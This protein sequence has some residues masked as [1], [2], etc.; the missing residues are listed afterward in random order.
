MSP[1]PRD[2]DSIDAEEAPNKPD[3]SPENDT[4]QKQ[5]SS[6]KRRTK[7]GCLIFSM[8]EE[9]YKM[10][11]REAVYRQQS[12]EP[13]NP[14]FDQDES[15]GSNQFR[16]FVSGSFPNPSFLSET[17]NTAPYQTF[18]PSGSSS[19][20]HLPF[21][22]S[23]HA[24]TPTFA[25]GQ[26]PLG[27]TSQSEWQ[28]VQNSVDQP[29]LNMLSSPGLVGPSRVIDHNYYAARTEPNYDQYGQHTNSWGPLG[30]WSISPQM[31]YPTPPFPGEMMFQDH[32]QSASD[33]PQDPSQFARNPF[34]HG[35]LQEEPH[36]GR[37]YHGDSSRQFTPSSGGASFPNS[38][39]PISA[40]SGYY[41]DPDD[42]FDVDSEEENLSYQA[43]AENLT[44]ALD[45]SEQH[46]RRMF[47]LNASRRASQ[48]L[49]NFRPSTTISPLREERNQHLFRHFVE[50]TSQCISVFERHHFSSIAGPARTLWNFTLPSMAMSHPALAHGILALGALH[51]SKLQKAS[52]ATAVKHFT[53]AVRR[54]GRLLGLPMRRLEIATLATVLVLGFYEVMSGDHSRWNLHL[55][56]ATSLVLEHD[57]AGMTRNAR[58]MRNGAKARVNQWMARFA[59]T[60]ENYAR[61]AGIPLALL[62]DID[63]D[64]DS[65][66]IS[67]LTGLSVNYDHQVQPQFPTQSLAASLTDKD[68]EDFKAKMDLRWWYCKQDVFQSCI[69]GDRLMLPFEDWKYCPP[70]GQLG[71]SANPYATLDHLCLIMARIADYSGK[72]RVRKQRALAAAG[73]EWRPPTWLFGPQGP[74]SGKSEGSKSPGLGTSSAS[75]HPGKS[76]GSNMSAGT[77]ASKA[78]TAPSANEGRARQSKPAPKG[79]SPPDRLPTIGMIPPPEAPIQMHSAFKTMD[80]N[81][82]DPAFTGTTRD[83]KPTQPRNLEDETSRAFKEHE[84]ITSAFDLFARSLGPDFDPLPYTDTPIATPFGPALVYRNPGIACIW[85]FYHVGRILLCRSHPEMPPAAMVAA[86][87]TA[88]LTRDHAQ[89]IGKICAGLYATQQYNQSGALDPTFAGACMEST[90]YL[91]FAGVQY[92]DPGQRG[93]T[94]SKLRDISQRCGWHT[95]AAVAA[96]C[97]TT[98]ERMGQAGRAPPYERKLDP[99]NHDDRQTGLGPR[100]PDASPMA[101]D[102]SNALKDHESAFVVHDRSLIDRSNSTRVHWALGLLS[103]EEDIKNM[104]LNE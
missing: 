34:R 48:T 92:T 104:K 16:T 61:V 96:A 28:S 76:G 19:Y 63:W 4:A 22:A 65:A 41:D 100:G 62:D 87:V 53:Y 56:G 85:A 86:S 103:V 64:V 80:A 37:Q 25:E 15:M 18:D 39:A 40:G 102:S 21:S 5:Q 71:R 30:P 89:A 7:T 9:T 29:A 66:L 27:P 47:R 52:D 81:L 57:Y 31:P 75:P 32:S 1:S 46:K 84:D 79:T 70:R 26:I 12:Q 55:S 68:I 91:L 54:V 82:K 98:W 42:P 95:S 94:I 43:A 45:Q 51:L 49:T 2:D 11:R 36:A 17:Q 97:E 44:H 23:Y 93:W 73:G 35:D 38:T 8:P 69:G 101:G 24:Y 50:V 10:R 33:Y 20:Q 3:D 78:T 99:R 90:F 72:D 67:R 88:H 58:R 59:L 77:N 14:R 74:A 60:E 6:A 83:N 13:H